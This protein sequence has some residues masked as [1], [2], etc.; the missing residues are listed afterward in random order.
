MSRSSPRTDDHGCLL[1][2]PCSRTSIRSLRVSVQ[3][4]DLIK[5][6]LISLGCQLPC[7]DYIL[8]VEIFFSLKIILEK[9]KKQE[10]VDLY[11]RDHEK[12]LFFSFFSK[13]NAPNLYDRDVKIFIQLLD[14]EKRKNHIQ[15]R[16]KER[17][18]RP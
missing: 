13:I 3:D 5:N 14:K 9:K 17:E 12:N 11:A 16:T 4:F 18:K 15:T 1:K 10:D 8:M 2:I 7:R 6:F